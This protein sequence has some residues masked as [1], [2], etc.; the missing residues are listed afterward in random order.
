MPKLRKPN[1][2]RMIDSIWKDDAQRKDFIKTT[3]ADES[4]RSFS[5]DCSKPNKDFSSPEKRNTLQMGTTT[6]MISYYSNLKN[7]VQRKSLLKSLK[8]RS[9]KRMGSHI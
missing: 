6:F 2:R 5:T 3:S 9:T 1:S 7:S 4:I 8:C